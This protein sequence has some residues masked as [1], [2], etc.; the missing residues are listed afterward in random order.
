MKKL[1]LIWLA[2]PLLFAC[3]G[4]P[5]T[6]R[7]V[8]VPDI[9]INAKE[10]QPVQ[11]DTSASEIKFTGYGPG[12]HHTGIFKLKQ[13]FISLQNNLITGGNFIISIASMQMEEK[14][15]AIE[16]KLRPHL[17]SPDFL[18]VTTY[19]LSTFTIFKAEPILNSSGKAT[20]YQVTGNLVLK[21]KARSISFPA[22]IT[23]TGSHVEATADF[24]I[25]R[26]WWDISYGNKRSLGNK[27]IS[28]TVRIQLTIVSNG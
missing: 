24:V 26:S 5:R 16:N 25:D 7:A 4:I 19:P 27:F 3:S 10:G 20:N 21:N 13:G 6:D 22:H 8:L 23:I 28:N 1:I 14:G 2:V 11:I 17:L 12:H 15:A 9:T 18:D